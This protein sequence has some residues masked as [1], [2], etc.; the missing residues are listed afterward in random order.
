MHIQQQK[1][2]EEIRTRK[3]KSLLNESMKIR[4]KE[5]MKMRNA[6]KRRM[7]SRSIGFQNGLGLS[8][9]VK[10]PKFKTQG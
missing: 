2:A 1:K 7:E 5:L 3:H 8:S 6:E 10:D 9:R 4:N